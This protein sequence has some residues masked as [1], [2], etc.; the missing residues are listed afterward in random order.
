MSV[1]GF[2]KALGSVL[3]FPMEH[4]HLTHR[5][6]DAHAAHTCFEQA[7]PLVGETDYAKAGTGVWQSQH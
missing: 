1:S 3:V 5:Q 7:M 6:A 2:C 4:K